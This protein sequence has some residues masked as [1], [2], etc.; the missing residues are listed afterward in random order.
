MASGMGAM[1][2]GAGR[3]FRLLSG[4]VPTSLTMIRPLSQGAQ[5][6]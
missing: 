6:C 5:T 3:S 2:C 4:G 1:G